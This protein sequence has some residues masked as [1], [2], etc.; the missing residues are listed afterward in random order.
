MKKLII[1]VFAVSLALA[2]TP[3][4]KLQKTEADVAE[5]DVSDSVE[6][7]IIIIDPEFERWY[8]SRYNQ[9]L[10][11]SNELYASMN[12]IGA[13]NWNQYFNTG[14]YARVI[15]NYLQYQ[16]GTDYGLEVNRRLYWYFKYIEERFRIPLLR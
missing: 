5:I 9:A 13:M 4:R 16:P 14:R 15:T 8:L 11:R 1:A 10:D 6:H 12:R 7:Q 3:S 2:C